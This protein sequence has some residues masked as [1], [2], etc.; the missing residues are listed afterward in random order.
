[1]KKIILFVFLI[2]ALLIVY[3][4]STAENVN[5]LEGDFEEM[6]FVR[7]ENNTG[8]VHRIYVFSLNDTLWTQ[9]RKHIDLLPHTKYGTTEVYYFLKKDVKSIEISLDMSGLENKTP[10]PLA[11]YVKNGQ[12]KITR[13]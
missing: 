3:S 11:H 2:T 10:K 5:S 4:L 6:A 8:P 7:N 13:K 12:G 1:M 9:M